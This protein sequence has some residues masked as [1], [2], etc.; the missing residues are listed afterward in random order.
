MTQANK[1]RLAIVGGGSSGLICLKHAVEMLPDWEVICFEKSGTI[2]GCWGRPYTGFVSTSTKYTT[3]F[4]TYAMYDSHCHV[5]GG[6]S[7]SEFFREGEY[8]EY[9]QSFSNQYQ[10]SEHI[11]LFQKV[12]RLRR[13]ESGQF[14]ELDVRN[15]NELNSQVNTFRFDAVII[16]T[17][18]AAVAKEVASEV[19]V[20]SLADLNQSDRALPIRGER[21]VV[22]GGGE[23]A[24]DYAVRLSKPELQNTVFLSLYTGIRVSPRYHP[25]RGVPSDFL[26]NRLMLSIHEDIRNWIGE[27]FVRFRILYQER[28]ERWFPRRQVAHDA[29]PTAVRNSIE[30]SSEVAVHDARKH[31]AYLLTKAAKDDLFNMFHNKSDDFLDSVANGRITIVGPATDSSY[32]I[33]KSF[34]SQ[35]DIEVNATLLIPSIGYR[36]TLEDLAPERLFL[37]DFYLGLSH[38]QFPNLFLVGF[39]R[40]IIGNI[41]SISEMQ[42]RCVMSILSGGI[43]LPSDMAKQ[44]ETNARH[45]Q[46]RFANLNRN[47]I[48]PV[49]M[50]P[51]CDHL[52]DWLDQ[53][54]TIRRVGSL[55]KWWRIQLS[56]ATTM[57]YWCQDEGVRSKYEASPIYMPTVLIVLLL[58]LKPLDWSY[59]ALLRVSRSMRGKS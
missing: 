34:E 20:G 27:R 33:C 25:I 36:S 29:S 55:W 52:A 1:R 7:R 56:P 23:S 39:A 54:P 8:G 38:V 14:W 40:P 59:R 50:F 51:Y 41:P 43:E 37:K 5:D 57:H 11:R 35:A 21:I 2:L 49:E 48:Y 24:V 18:L 45:N 13:D 30:K 4:S 12:E 15:V 22:L 44:H 9:L 53:S 31:W 28:M 46:K 42:A 58:G 26:R 47:A 32:R 10:L 6:A 17:G 16:A 3:Q 19:R